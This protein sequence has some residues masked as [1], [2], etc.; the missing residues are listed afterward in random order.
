MCVSSTQDGK[1]ED[2]CIQNFIRQVYEMDNERDAVEKRYNEHFRIFVKLWKGILSE[3]KELNSKFKEFDSARASVKAKNK[4]M[5]KSEAKVRDGALHAQ[6]FP[7]AASM[8][9]GARAVGK[10]NGDLLG[11]GHG[12]SAVELPASRARRARARGLALG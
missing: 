1:G 7:A 9:R 8:P 10:Q 4:K 3:K 5:G 12:R 11:C 2:P 6:L